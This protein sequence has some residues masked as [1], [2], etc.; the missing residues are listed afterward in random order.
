M[1]STCCYLRSYSNLQ[2]NIQLRHEFSVEIEPYKRKFIADAHTAKGE[3][4]TFHLFSDVRIFADG[5]GYCDTCGCVHNAP[6]EVDILFVGPSCKSISLENADRSSYKHCYS[7]GEGSSGYTYQHGVKGAVSSTNPALLF[8]ENVL[9]VMFAVNKKPSPMEATG[10]R[11][12]S[13]SGFRCCITVVYI[14]IVFIYMLIN[15]KGNVLNAHRIC[16]WILGNNQ[17]MKMVL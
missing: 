2:V 13:N 15:T 11:F 9:G 16:E 7:T 3:K 4:P 6:A 8:F 12:I 17:D 14:Y 10:F 5:K 1:F